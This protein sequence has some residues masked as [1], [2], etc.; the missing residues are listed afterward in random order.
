VA[1]AISA[2]VLA[3]EVV[4][5]YWRLAPMGRAILETVIASWLLA[6]AWLV[7]AHY[8]YSRRLRHLVLFAALLTLCLT[9][10]FA[11]ALPAA[12]GSRSTSPLVAS[13][14]CGEL[15]VAA[16]LVA[17]SRMPADRCVSRDGPACGFAVAGSLV[18][19]GMTLLGG[20]LIGH[21]LLGGVN[22]RGAFDVVVRRPVVSALV[23]ATAALFLLAAVAAIRAHE[24]SGFAPILAAA[25]VLMAAARVTYLVLPTT[26]ARSIDA[27]HGLRL[28]AAG[29][30]LLA[31][32][33]HA[34]RVPALAARTA[35]VAERRRVAC[36]LHDG[37]AQDLALIAAHG[38]RIAAVVGKDHPVVVAAQHA[39]AVSRGALITLSQGEPETAR[40]ALEGMASELRRRFQIE[41][42]VVVDVV[43]EFTAEE[44]EHLTRIAREAI[45]NAWRHGAARDVAISLRERSDGISFRIT[46]DGCGMAGRT[47]AEAGHGLGLC[48]MRERASALGGAMTVVPGERGG[49]QVEI[50]LP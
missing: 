28:G 34:H 36:D 21:A 40:G 37:L 3:G 48:M 45:T 41:I 2:A 43:R 30:L 44:V 49:T 27:A 16:L 13:G 33:R 9:S 15:V 6:T 38:P 10:C 25:A 26:A 7:R 47:P 14:F 31:V 29:M 20:W 35:A 46:D 50:R 23:L 8:A 11:Y 19:V 4:D 12:L 1:G 18:A 17:F 39:L 42:T 32:L 22:P 5:P 24:P